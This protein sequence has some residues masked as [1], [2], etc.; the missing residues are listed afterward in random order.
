MLLSR[1]YYTDNVAIL[2]KDELDRSYRVWSSNDPSCTRASLS[3]NQMN[4]LP[5]LHKMRGIKFRQNKTKHK[6]NR[7]SRF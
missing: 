6:W 3:L 4:T 5:S 2:L 7:L 1:S